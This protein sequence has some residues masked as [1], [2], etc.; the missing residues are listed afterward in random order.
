MQADARVRRRRAGPGI[1]LFYQPTLLVLGAISVLVTGYTVY[2]VL[3][4]ISLL[5]PDGDRFVGFG[6]LADMLRDSRA[7]NAT[8]NTLIYVVCASGIELAAGTGIALFLNRDFPGRHI[9]RT[10][11]LIPLIMTPVVAGLIWRIFYDPNSGIANYLLSLVGFPDGVDWLGDPHIA[12]ASLILVD[13]WQWTPF[14]IVIVMAALES[15]EREPI[16]AAM[17]DGANRWQMTRYVILPMVRDAILVAATLRLIDSVKVFDIIY[18]MTRGGPALSTET[19]NM[20]SYL[21]A[22][23]YFSLG[24]AGT[25]ALVLTILVNVGL[26]IVY[27]LATGRMRQA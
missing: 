7:W 4:R 8:A 21:T 11:L 1:R 13:V 20:Y 10:L 19:L 18:V 9:V 17:I 14:V 16:E 23:N 2:L 24:Y 25:I 5:Q 27:R 26:V 12:L 22:F 3:H 6:N 15:M